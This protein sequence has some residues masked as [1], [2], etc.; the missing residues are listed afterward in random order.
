MPADSLQAASATTYTDE[1]SFLAALPT[2][3][4][5][6]S[7]DAT[8]P[9]AEGTCVDAAFECS[10][11]PGV[12]L[13]SPNA[14]LPG[15]APIR[16][17]S[18]TA[19]PGSA[20][21]VLTGGSVAGSPGYDQII[22]LEFHPTAVGV[23]FDLTDLSP[24]SEC[25]A[26]APA[27]LLVEFADGSSQ[28]WSVGDRSFSAS[29]PEYFGI[30]SSVDIVRVTI[31][32]GRV[33][34]PGFE[35][36][37]YDG[38]G[39]DGLAFSSFHP[40]ENP[41]LCFRDLGADIPSTEVRG[42]AT[43]DK[44]GDTGISAVALSEDAT[45][46]VLD[47]NPPLEPGAPR[48]DF[49]VTRVRTG[50]VGRGSV[51]ATDG[52]GRTCTLP[53]QLVDVPAGPVEDL[54]LCQGDGILFQVSNSD[55]SL[56]GG[57]S[58]CSSKIYTPDDP[59]LPPG[60]DPS[61]ETD[62]T[63]CRL[64]TIESPVAGLTEMVYKK[65]GT[66]D[67]SLRLLFSRSTDGGLTFPP[68]VDITESV[69]EIAN[70]VPDPTRLGGKVQ[71]SP[72]KVMCAIQVPVDCSTIPPTYD[73][74]ADTYPLC[75]APET[76]PADCNDQISR[77]N[78]GATETC[79]GMD[80]NCDGLVDNG[81]PGGGETCSVPGELGA[82]ATGRTRCENSLIVCDATVSPAPNDPDCDGIDDDCDGQTDEDYAPRA[83]TCGV[84]AC[85]ATGST[86]CVE[87]VERD[88]CTAGTPAS[89]DATCNNVDDDC[90]GS[91]DENFVS[92]P[93]A[94]GSGA[95]ASTGSTSCVN[96][97][98]VDSCKPKTPGREVCNG[99]DDDCDGAVDEAKVFSGYLQPVNDDGSSI[100]QKGRVVPFK[101]KLTT[102]SGAD[103][104]TERARFSIIYY[105]T[106]GV[107]TVIEDPPAA[108]KANTDGYYRWDSK[109]KQ[110]I[111]NFDTNGL[112]AGSSYTARTTLEDGTTYD[113]IITIRQ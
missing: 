23:G 44:V 43:D 73:Y 97:E 8:P 90:D 28:T 75:P 37:S 102:C 74:D 86:S 99:V 56:P 82:C 108:G 51:I 15:Y 57:T 42:H 72:V 50:A 47:L 67:P 71:W 78:P 41:P 65:D 14:S 107:G 66:F 24:S 101:F 60:Y 49:S 111:Y 3:R 64:L 38:Y 62:P 87:G 1:A 109:G 46:L 63:P 94:C 29:V 10:S 7:F 105:S 6:Q 104:S 34:F 48:A 27:S 17:T 106:P 92:S 53:V 76:V 70:V 45:N 89:S 55:P 81:N 32:S 91:V 85:R 39:L 2:E 12:T 11:I 19:G 16:V 96:G 54:V 69:Q 84:G 5:I 26:V 18:A 68:F 98:V 35:G 93:T 95:C 33:V 59:A 36:T 77:I 58:A 100:F 110:Y 103:I 52:S 83:T 22:V 112:N 25:A 61:P 9:W 30:T 113:V 40:D 79:N 80:D 31:T 20:P 4:T 13:R 88:S 21:H